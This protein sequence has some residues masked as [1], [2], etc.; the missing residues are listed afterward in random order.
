MI[1]STGFFGAGPEVQ[2]YT[3][4]QE[5]ISECGYPDC[6]EFITRPDRRAVNANSKRCS[7]RSQW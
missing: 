3:D 6:S 2:Q 4:Y 7:E 5:W 1:S